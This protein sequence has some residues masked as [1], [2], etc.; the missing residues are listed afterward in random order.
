MGGLQLDSLEHILKG[1]NSGPAVIPGDPDNS[2]LIRAVSYR[3]ERFKMPPQGKLPEAQIADLREWVS[4]GVHWA[5]TDASTKSVAPKPYVITDEQRKFWAFQ[6]IRNPPVPS[7]HDTGWPRKPIDYFIL[8]A[9]EKKGMKPASVADRRTLI[10]RATF[11]LLGL[12]PTP[13]E[14]NAFLNDVS[15]DAFVRV[16]ERLLASPQ[17]G[18]RWGRFWLDVARYA[19]EDILFPNGDP[20]PNAF[21][22]RDWVIQSFNDDLPYD[23]FVKAQ[24]AGDLIE[25]ETGR[26]LRPGLGFIA[27]GPWYYKIVEPPKAHA[28]ERHDRLDT[29]T[30]GFLG[31]TVA[32]A[33]CHDHKYDPIPT[34]DYYALAGVFAN[35]EAKEYPLASA[36]IVKKYDEQSKKIADQEE[37][38]KTALKTERIRLNS[39]FAMQLADYLVASR[40]G[41]TKGLN[42]D[43][44]ARLRTYLATPGKAHSYLEEWDHLSSAQA[45][46]RFQSLAKRV[47]REH[48]EIEA[49]NERVL[50]DAKKSTD[51][52]DIF[53]K[54]CNVVTRTLDHDKFVLWTDLFGAKQRTDE[55]T[56]GVFYFEDDKIDAVLAPEAKERIGE[57]R[58]K[59][60]ALK[61]ALPER[62]PFLH[63]V[64]DVDRP[65]DLKQA[66]RGDP[67]NLGD[68]I[69]RHFLSILSNGDPQLLGN[70][71]G[72]LEL[73]EAIASPRNPLTAR[74]MVNRIWQHH[75]GAGIVRTPSN[76]GKIGDRP[77]NP[78]LLDYLATKFV[79][80]GWSIKAMHRE[81]MLS[82]AYALSTQN[83]S[84]NAAVD[85]DNR[86]FWR[87]NRTRLDAEALRDS[88]L[89]VCG[90]LNLTA[91]GPAFD[92]GKDSLR[93]T[94][95][96]KVSRQK[97]ERMLTLFDFPSPDITSEQRVTTNVP[98]QKLFFLN[99]DL[100]LHSA[101][102]LAKRVGQFSGNDTARIQYLYRLLY[103]R[104]GTPS[105]LAKGMSFLDRSPDRSL[106]WQRYAQVLLSSNEF[107]FV[108]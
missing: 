80:S 11:D 39:A 30:R 87:A 9:L 79:E 57:M 10:R 93:R 100:M 83:V 35:I 95:Y 42:P 94:V 65:M 97:L 31:L 103:S 40:G 59:L 15:P 38:I 16:V 29:L 92:W 89:Y 91:G 84:F 101:A 1:G 70:G 19:D 21:R 34:K 69:P 60:E 23:L 26:S 99:S 13:E 33:R 18:E 22:Y 20:F 3:H 4:A 82:A 14:V 72:R 5:A 37:A 48:D 46:S 43:I 24:I 44:V 105:E 102:N 73:A 96:G 53:C 85:P 63:T 17:Y 52:Y 47:N 106:G 49:H 56:P 78:E 50:E 98:P 12:P 66:L 64:S 51:P 27:L 76:F 41:S 62:Y 77:S 28:D 67:Y 88:I 81:M 71:S 74:V 36:D 7:V 54:G 90:D 8:A 61:K 108:E 32:C 86:M 75:F 25:K 6:P 68:A 2:L 58:R 107:I 55:K 104:N 45:A